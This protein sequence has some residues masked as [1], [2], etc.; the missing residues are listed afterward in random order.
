MRAHDYIIAF[1]IAP[2]V[3]AQ[4]DPSRY[5]YF[6][7]AG[8]GLSSSLP[9]GNGRVAAAVYGTATEKITLNEN[10]VWSG[11]W[12]DRGNSKSLSALASI[13]QKLISGDISSAGSE[14]LDAMA[15]NPQSPKQYHPTVDMAIDF[16]H[17]GTLGGY[18]RVLDTLQGT[19]MTTYTLGGVN[20]T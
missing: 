4:W 16:G 7:T 6:N 12:Q 5:L 8:S 17:S 3:L 1:L 18:M 11:Q 10:S 2:V 13:R 15:G 19:A 14:T 9:I 20:Y